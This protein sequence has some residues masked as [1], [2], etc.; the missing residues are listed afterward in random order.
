MN[1][2]LILCVIGSS[3]NDTTVQTLYSVV[4]IMF[5]VL[6]S[7]I[8]SITTNAILNKDSNDKIKKQIKSREFVCILLFM[9]ITIF[10]IFHSSI[11]N[12]QIYRIEFT[13]K[14]FAAFVLIIGIIVYIW[15]FVGIE[16][17]KNHIEDIILEEQ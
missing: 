14:S 8:L 16:K 5:S 10:F 7:L 9:V 15:M 3:I 17:I 11:N 12:I 4:G 13:N 1:S 6:M 2:S